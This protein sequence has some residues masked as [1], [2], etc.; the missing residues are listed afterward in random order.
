VLYFFGQA[1]RLCVNSRNRRQQPKTLDKRQAATKQI[2]L[3]AFAG[4]SLLED[5]LRENLK[6]QNYK[7]NITKFKVNKIR[8]E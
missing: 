7:Y 6:A 2:L 4:L 5:P 8:N 3:V 1:K